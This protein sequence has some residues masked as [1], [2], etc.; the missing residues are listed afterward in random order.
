MGL[1][2]TREAGALRKSSS[3]LAH[4]VQIHL[5]LRCKQLGRQAFPGEVPGARMLLAEALKSRMPD[6]DQRL[7]AL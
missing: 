3:E 5:D 2:L 1:H 7:T 4:V 6:N